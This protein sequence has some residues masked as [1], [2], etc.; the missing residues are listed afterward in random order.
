MNW[1]L[2]KKAKEMK[3]KIEDGEEIENSPFGGS[4]GFWYDITDGGYF[5]INEIIEDFELQ[6]RIKGAVDLLKSLEDEVYSKIVPEF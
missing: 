1:C 2:S 4:D 5:K 3:K 6:Q